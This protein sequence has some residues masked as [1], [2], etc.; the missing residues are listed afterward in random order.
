M[1]NYQHPSQTSHSV[2][3]A[4]LVTRPAADSNMSR[5]TVRTFRLDLWI[6]VWISSVEK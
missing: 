4:T 2:T 3:L 1:M 6:S 5:L